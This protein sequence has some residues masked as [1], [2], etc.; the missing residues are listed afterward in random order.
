MKNHIYWLATAATA[1]ALV[2]SACG[3]SNSGTETTASTSPTAETGTT[4]ATSPTATTET[5]AASSATTATSPTAATSP[6]ASSAS[7]PSLIPTPA[8]SEQTRG[9]DPLSDDGIHLYF[10]VNGASKDVMNAYKAA[11]E[12][13]G[14][15]VET[16]V[17]S[18]GAQGGGATYTA[19][20]GNAYSVID[21]GGFESTTYID[22]CA[23]PS[24]PAEPVCTRGGR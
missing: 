16:I 10:L 14:W 23:W 6:N 20:R 24:K 11:F 9:P 17:T 5:T 1:V 3:S 8:N 2:G 4:D 18:G 22:V 12:D 15:S 13:K 19:T 21:G 7:L